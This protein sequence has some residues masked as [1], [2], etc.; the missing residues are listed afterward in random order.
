MQIHDIPVLSG[1]TRLGHVRELRDDRFAL[2]ERMNRERGDVARLLALGSS[3]VFVNSPALLHEVLVEKAKHFAK[4]RSM[5]GALRPIAGNGVFTSEGEVWRRQRKLMAPLFTAAQVARYADVA[6][7]SAEDAAATLAEGEVVDMARLSMHLAM[8]VAGKTLFGIDTL[9]E[10]DE[11]GAALTTL[12]GWANAATG[13]LAFATQVIVVDGV[14]ELLGRFAPSLAARAKP[15]RDAAYERI[16]WPGESSRRLEAAVRVV[17]ERVAR[18]IADRRAAGLARRDLLSV[19]TSAR[20][21]EGRAMSDEELRD[22]IGTLFVAGHETTASGLAWSLY[23]LGRHPEALER[24]RAEASALQGRPATAA[25]LPRLGFCLQV[26]KEAMRLYPPIY[27][28][29]RRCLVDVRIGSF[30]LPRDTALII[31]PWTLHRRPEI[32][33]DP[34]RFDPSR[35]EPAAEQARDKLAYLPFGAGPRICIGNHFA[36]MQGPLALATLLAR[37]DLEPVTR[38]AIEPEAYATLRPKGGVPMR[39]T[40]CRALRFSAASSP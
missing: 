10:A 36:L 28:M 26:F 27:V 20:D 17:D 6:S 8:R 4:S 5:R 31:S 15:Y 2:F 40:A 7:S 24:A 33:P 11:L 29:A 37:L 30:D 22:E 18:M 23:L 39:V 9:D 12:L 35:F 14:Y 32:W 16:H 21:E 34:E 19:L 3:F 38:A 13:S 25:D 1:A